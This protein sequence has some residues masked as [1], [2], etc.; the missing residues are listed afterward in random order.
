MVNC[1]L[2]W[3]VHEFFGVHNVYLHIFL[4]EIWQMFHEGAIVSFGE[5]RISSPFYV[6]LKVPQLGILTTRIDETMISEQKMPTPNPLLGSQQPAKLAKKV[7]AKPTICFWGIRWV[8]PLPSIS[9]PSRTI[10]WDCRGFLKKKHS[11]PGSWKIW[12]FGDP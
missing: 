4:F 3:C 11:S 1:F 9:H 12:R 5:R 2:G 6:T 10:T 7:I 8:I